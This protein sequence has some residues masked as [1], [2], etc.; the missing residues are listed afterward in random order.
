MKKRESFRSFA[1]SCL[2][3]EAGAWFKLG[4]HTVAQGGDVS[5]YTS[6]TARVKEDKRDLIPAVTHVD[7]SSRLQTVTPA[8]DPGYHRLISAFHAATGVP[9]VL[10]TSF[11][12]LPGEPIVESPRDAVRSFLASMG[13]LEMLVMGD[14]VIRRKAIDVRTLL[15]EEGKNGMRTSLSFPRRAG[16][17]RYE[18]TFAVGLGDD[19]A[20]PGDKF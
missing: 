19:G 9:M 15:G 6:L 2:V 10:N 3:E 7:G 16:P 13:A 18:T 20:V 17:V 1:L 12:T 4:G 8:A 5:P 14:Y 11:N